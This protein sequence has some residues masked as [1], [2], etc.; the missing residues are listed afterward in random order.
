MQN[1]IQVQRFDEPYPLLRIDSIF[2]QPELDAMR[3]YVETLTWQRN[4][5]SFYDQ[6]DTLLHDAVDWPLHSVL[7]NERLHDLRSCL[8]Q[9]FQTE[10]H[11]FVNICCHKLEAGQYIDKHTDTPWLGAETL[12]LV[13]DLD[14]DYEGGGFYVYDMAD[15]RTHIPLGAN[16]GVAFGLDDSSY[17]AVGRV[18]AGVRYT[19]IF[20]FWDRDTELVPSYLKSRCLWFMRDR[21]ISP[22]L[23][24]M[25]L[26]GFHI[27]PHSGSNLLR[28]LYQTYLIL[29][30]WGCGQDTKLAGLFHS[31]FDSRILPIPLDAADEDELAI[32]LGERALRLVRRFSFRDDVGF[33]PGLRSD[34]DDDE[35][36][37]WLIDLANSFEQKQ[38]MDEEARKETVIRA[39][40]FSECLPAKSVVDLLHLFPL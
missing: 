18:T 20:S 28:H 31:V 8:E 25:H 40:A 4:I 14:D 30:A 35:T 15:N 19:I 39:M 29:D 27:V 22:Q 16:R 6:H 36:S 13:V 11:D 9:G 10:L 34:D 1:S 32:L 24:F 2:T 12:R 7:T 33:R 23:D 3:S 38:T 37:L 17:H 21:R 26:R 5:R